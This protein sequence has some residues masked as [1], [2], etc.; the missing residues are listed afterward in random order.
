MVVGV[1][2]VWVMGGGGGGGV[3]DRKE[4]VGEGVLCLRVY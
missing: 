2:V 4:V 1:M 3:D